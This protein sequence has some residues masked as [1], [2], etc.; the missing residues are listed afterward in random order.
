MYKYT[1]HYTIYSVVFHNEI[2]YPTT[3]KWVMYLIMV[4]DKV[5][6]WLMPGRWFSPGPPVSFTNKT[7]CHVI[8][9]I[10]L[11]VVLKPSNKHFQKMNVQIKIFFFYPLINSL[12]SFLESHVIPFTHNATVFLNLGLCVTRCGIKCI[13]VSVVSKLRW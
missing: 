10:L 9:E 4:S 1:W 7:V 3:V 12:E 5:C 8:T 2:W 13:Y 11:K 6:Q